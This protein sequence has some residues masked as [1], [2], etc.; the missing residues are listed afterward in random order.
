MGITHR[1]DSTGRQGFLRDS[2]RIEVE[3][4][5]ERTRGLALALAGAFLVLKELQ[6]RQDAA[7]AMPSIV[8]SS[9]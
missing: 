7:A 2:V 3:Q 1:P 8:A 4:A 9:S 6:R 5:A